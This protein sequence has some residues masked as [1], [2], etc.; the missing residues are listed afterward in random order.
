MSAA[1]PEPA[2]AETGDDSAYFSSLVYDA[3]IR[4]TPQSDALAISL[5]DKVQN[6]AMLLVPEHR[7]RPGSCAG[8]IPL[9]RHAIAHCRVKVVCKLAARAGPDRGAALSLLKKQTY[10]LGEAER[11]YAGGNVLL[12][13]P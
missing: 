13:I 1:S 8:P 7:K 9:I 10:F 6:P 11:T 3:M 5:I 4:G 2:A 12:A